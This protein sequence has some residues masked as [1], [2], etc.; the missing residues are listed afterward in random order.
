MTDY[1][2]KNSTFRTELINK[3]LT[4]QLKIDHSMCNCIYKVNINTSS[5]ST[6]EVNVDGKGKAKP[7][8]YATT[9]V[10]LGYDMKYLGAGAY[11][12][13]AEIC[14]DEKCDV[15]YAIKVIMYQNKRIY[16]PTT[17]PDRPE[18]IEVRIFKILN[19]RILYPNISPHIALYIQ[20]F[21]CDGVPVLWKA[22]VKQSYDKYSSNLLKTTDLEVS[23]KSDKSIVMISELCMF[24]SLIDFMS[25]N[26]K[27][28]TEKKLSNLAFQFVYTMAQIQQVIPGFRHNDCHGSNILMQD[29]KNYNKVSER[30]YIYHY[31]NKFFRLPVIFMQLKLWDFD[32]ANIV[33]ETNNLKYQTFDEDEF[34]Y[35]HVKNDYYDLHLFIND[36]RMFKKGVSP[37]EKGSLPLI[38]EDSPLM[39][40]YSQIVPDK[41]YGRDTA[42]TGYG[43]LRPN[44]EYIT[45]DQL[46]M[47]TAP[48]D[49]EQYLLK[50]YEV[51]LDQINPSTIM[52]VYGIDREEFDQLLKVARTNTV[53]LEEKP[54]KEISTQPSSTESHK[55]PS[56]SDIVK[57]ICELPKK[58][59]VY[60]HGKCKNPDQH[61]C[62]TDSRWCYYCV[63]QIES[64]KLPTLP[65]KKGS[66]TF[67]I[68]N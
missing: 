1:L 61:A 12:L 51:T 9:L 53:Q 52:G 26:P 55:K 32:L 3:L 21:K 6:L 45:P 10:N 30:F 46:L 28:L 68:P 17:N 63:S 20:D 16:E 25:T 22:G 56:E 34:G 38:S 19:Q 24:G 64:C 60:P 31:K 27:F 2:F 40:W 59:T 54:K 15:S 42:T 50:T 14:T 11:G 39:K 33:G 65:R 29:D 4:G 13:A 58:K 47:G 44:I 8:D 41:Y 23:Y 62:S 67:K 43:R 18:N 37:Y 66:Y 48:Q 7:C 36:Q 49:T 57:S 35:R 5:L